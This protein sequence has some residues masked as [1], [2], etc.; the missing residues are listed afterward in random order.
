MKVDWRCVLWL[1]QTLFY[2]GMYFSVAPDSAVMWLERE[3]QKTGHFPADS[4][5]FLLSQ[6][7]LYPV[8]GL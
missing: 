1:W 2:S 5:K 4:D 3:K 7:A 6:K 8:I